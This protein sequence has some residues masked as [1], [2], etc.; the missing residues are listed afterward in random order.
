M[1]GPASILYGRGSSG[2]NHQSH[3][4]ETVARPDPQVD[5]TYRSFDVKRLSADFGQPISDSANFR[6]NAAYED[7]GGFRR[8]YFLERYLVA[9]SLSSN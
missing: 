4:Q 8:Q 1:K 7:S 6:L 5:L 2:G 9:P 3:H